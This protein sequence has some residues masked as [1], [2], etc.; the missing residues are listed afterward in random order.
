M[1]GIA[2]DHQGQDRE[3]IAAMDATALI[4]P[5]GHFSKRSLGLGRIF[6]T[7]ARRLRGAGR[8]RNVN[9]SRSGSSCFRK[10]SA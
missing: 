2:E 9:A 6:P 4:K 3:I 8:L 5:I 1:A 7:I 10:P